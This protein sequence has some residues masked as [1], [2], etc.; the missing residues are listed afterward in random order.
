MSAW[1]QDC[2]VAF[3]VV[4]SYIIICLRFCS[5]SAIPL[6]GD[7]FKT[8]P[9]RSTDP[10]LICTILNMQQKPFHFLIFISL[11]VQSS[12]LFTTKTMLLTF[13]VYGINVF[14]M[15]HV[16]RHNQISQ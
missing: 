7:I 4:Y 12:F 9:H 5:Y 8:K 2:P 15:L 14:Q 6:G 3:G 11:T 16:M 1:Q 13:T 10:S